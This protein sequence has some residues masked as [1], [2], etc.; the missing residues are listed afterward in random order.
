[1][2][3]FIN[4]D[5]DGEKKIKAFLKLINVM[6]SNTLKSI[7]LKSFQKINEFFR[8]FEFNSTVDC[9]PL[10][11]ISIIDDGTNFGFSDNF[12]KIMVD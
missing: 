9:P 4:F 5:H 8:K 6:M 1:M 11:Q 3:R 2:R 10:L 7:V 12:R